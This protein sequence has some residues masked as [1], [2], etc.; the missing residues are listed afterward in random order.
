MRVIYFIKVNTMWL[1]ALEACLAMFI[2]VFIVWW[3]M[4]HGRTPDAPPQ[5]KK[6]DLASSKDNEQ[7]H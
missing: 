4:F 5:D 7:S 1:L 3:T 6:Q 2:L